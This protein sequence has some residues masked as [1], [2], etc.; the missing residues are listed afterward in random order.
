[1]VA[2]RSLGQEIGRLVVAS[3][4]VYAVGPTSLFVLDP[5]SLTV[6]GRT[7]LGAPEPGAV[8]DSKLA[9]AGDWA[10]VLRGN[11][12][13][14]VNVADPAAPTRVGE[15]HGH[16]EDLAVAPDGRHLLLAR[17]VSQMLPGAL[18]VLDVSNPRRPWQVAEL[19]GGGPATGC[20]PRRPASGWWT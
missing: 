5:T 17:P 1:V 8:G 14:L 7:V 10:Y 12:L 11:G 3:G 6:V 9:V 16:A 13:E 15:W 18:L 2:L 20:G 4:L 19:A